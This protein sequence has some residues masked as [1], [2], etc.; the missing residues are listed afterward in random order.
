MHSISG[1]ARLLLFLNKACPEIVIHRD[2]AEV[3]TPFGSVTTIALKRVTI[4]WTP[5]LKSGWTIRLSAVQKIAQKLPVPATEVAIADI[6]SCRVCPESSE[7]RP[8]RCNF[9][10]EPRVSRHTH[11]VRRTPRLRTITAIC[12]ATAAGAALA[13][14]TIVVPDDFASL[15]EALDPTVSGIDPGDIIVLR[16]SITYFGTFDVTVADLTIRAAA[17]DSPVLDANGAGSVIKVNVGTG[18]VT[19]EGLTIQDGSRVGNNDRGAGVEVVN[20]G[21]VTVRDCLIRDNNALDFGGGAIGGSNFSLVVEDSVLR[22]N[23]ASGGGA[24]VLRFSGD[25]TISNTE[26]IENTATGDNGGAIFCDST[27]TV[28][29]EDSRFEGNATSTRG[30]G[31]FFRAASRLVISNTT[32]ASNTAI[33]NAGSDGGAMFIE[34]VQDTTVS[35]SDF[36]ANLANGAGGVILSFLDTGGG[37]S[38][39]Y[40]NSRFV[41]NESSSSTIAIFGGSVDVVNCEFLGNTTLRA[42]DGD[43]I[44]GALRYRASPGGQRSFGRVFNSVFD[45]NSAEQGGAIV[46][47]TATVEITNSTF[48]NNTASSGAAVRSNQSD[49]NVTISNNVFSGNGS[50]ALNFAGANGIRNTSFNLFDN[51]ED[52]SGVFEG[53]LL[54]TDPLFVDASNGDYALQPGSPAIDAGNS[55]LYGFGPFADLAGNLRGQDDLATPDTGIARTGPVIDMG[56]F[57]FNATAACP[58]DLAAPFGIVNFFDIVEYINLFN[59]GCP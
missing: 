36:V 18:N 40:I 31:A 50:D 42:G 8:S 35:E 12:I 26:F 13:Q 56:A 22:E 5:Q 19:L 53:N 27:D 4:C 46:V 55:D 21:L 23:T 3:E 48:V 25:L 1:P 52:V 37:D 32:F 39:E 33:G 6:Y 41:D 15:Q 51:E 34:A 44:G 43:S 24:I 16:D 28:T 14:D 45:G 54:S 38:I 58:A 17:G 20:A 10:H 30:G 49:T 29:I 11:N 9:F 59:Q 47:G 2:D 57:E 7:L